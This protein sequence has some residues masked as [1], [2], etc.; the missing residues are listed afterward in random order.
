[1]TFRSILNILGIC[2]TGAFTG[3]MLTI[4]LILGDYWKSIPPQEFLDWFSA[5]EHL[6]IRMIAIVSV[7][8]AV[9]VIA[10]LFLALRNPR[11]RLWWAVSF[12]A[13]LVLAVI[14]VVVHLPMN[15][16]FS[17]KSVP[18]DQVGATIDRWLA[19]HW[20]R[21]GLGLLATVAAV[22][23]TTAYPATRSDSPS[24]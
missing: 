24:R 22:L 4:A 16:S 21:I 17:A 23:G 5:N 3:T 9:G 1:M 11:S 18:L 20:I 13:L 15:A 8:A 7:P 14:T 10:S 19:W 2:G 12:A 6:L